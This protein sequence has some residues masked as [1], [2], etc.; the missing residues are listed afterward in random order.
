[1]SRGTRPPT[2]PC[3]RDET[4]GCR[5]C[6]W[7]IWR[8]VWRASRGIPAGTVCVSPRLGVSVAL[9]LPWKSAPRETPTDR[10]DADRW[11]FPPQRL[12]S[13]AKLGSSVR[14]G[15]PKKRIWEEGGSIAD[16][17]CLKA[18]RTDCNDA[19]GKEEEVPVQGEGYRRDRQLVAAGP[20]LSA[21]RHK[22][23]GRLAT[24]RVEHGGR[25]PHVIVQ[26]VLVGH[27]RVDRPFQEVACNA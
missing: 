10:N 20:M 3:L 26:W 1:M 23:V 13:G 7:H 11:K 6:V 16:G 17:P 18:K 27:V 14:H 22:L 19:G 2:A 25:S 4:V 8:H 21:V 24:L 12:N 5:G 15:N 9:D